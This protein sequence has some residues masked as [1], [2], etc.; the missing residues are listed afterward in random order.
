MSDATP[1]RILT[2]RTEF[3]EALRE[4]FRLAQIAGCKEIFI[5]DE[6][7]ADWPLSERAVLE[8]L[9]QWAGARRRLVVLARHFDELVRRHARWVEWRR[10]WS[11]IVDCR[12]LDDRDASS[13]PSMLLA[14]G[15]LVV[16]VLD[17]EHFRTRVSMDPTDEVRAF[18]AL[19]ACLQRSAPSFPATTLGL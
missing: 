7:F 17:R 8:S 18:D 2:T 12:A 10:Q 14:P 3:Q 13:C 1:H 19:D 4:G 15:A 11:H 6:D 9:T 5:S 16:R